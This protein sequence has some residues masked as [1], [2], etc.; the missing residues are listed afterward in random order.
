[1]NHVHKALFSFCMAVVL[2]APLCAQS[3]IAVETLEHRFLSSS[4]PG[5][6]QAKP[7]TTASGRVMKPQQGTIVIEHYPGYRLLI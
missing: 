3:P 5:M 1:V 7:G 6:T 2:S 4:Y